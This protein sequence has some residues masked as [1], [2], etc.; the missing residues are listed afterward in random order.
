MFFL[1]LN[2]V[3]YLSGSEKTIVRDIDLVTGNI[4]YRIALGIIQKNGKEYISGIGLLGNSDGK[5]YSKR[6]WS[7]Q[8][9]MQPKIN[10][11]NLFKYPVEIKA[12]TKRCELN[13]DI[14]GG[15]STIIFRTETQSNMLFTTIQ[16]QEKGKL[17]MLL[18]AYPG[19]FNRQD[20]SLN[21]RHA[22]T[23]IRNFCFPSKKVIGKDE[24]WIYFYDEKNNP[25][26]NSYKS[27]C[28]VLYNPD[29][30][31]LVK[32]DVQ[33]YAIYTTLTHKDLKEI[34]YIFWE[35]PGKDH[36]KALEYMKSLK[37]EYMKSL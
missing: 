28:S 23:A 35:F 30:I 27:T 31:E 4:N 6:G 18:V 33:N 20:T 34:H 7:S 3:S 24:P 1:L 13:F 2:A 9:F 10:G 37:I 5:I 25:T 17:E 19:E 12:D 36:F 15:R 26:G 14:P 11:E 29:E 8:G 16:M 21:Q 22:A 32:V